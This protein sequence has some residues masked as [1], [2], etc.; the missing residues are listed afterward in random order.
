MIEFFVILNDSE[1]QCQTQT[2]GQ[3]ARKTSAIDSKL[4]IVHEKNV[5]K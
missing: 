3:K 4:E 5:P 2:I 1:I